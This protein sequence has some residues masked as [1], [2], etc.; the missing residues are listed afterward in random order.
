[1]TV[2]NF[3]FPGYLV[4]DQRV[5]YKPYGGAHTSCAM[6][7]YMFIIDQTSS[8]LH[9]HYSATGQYLGHLSTRKLSLGDE[10]IRRIGCGKRGILHLWLWDNTNDAPKLAAYNVM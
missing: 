4:R 9:V 7:R 1:M 8:K 10:L 6:K 2:Y 5:Q 3:E